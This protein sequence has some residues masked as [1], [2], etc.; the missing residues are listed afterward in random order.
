MIWRPCAREAGAALKGK[1]SEAGL[2]T[3][4]GPKT[5]FGKLLE[6]ACKHYFEGTAGVVTGLLNKFKSCV[7]LTPLM[8]PLSA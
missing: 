6:R 7:K 4:L 5:F 3:L 1:D 8:I 2:E